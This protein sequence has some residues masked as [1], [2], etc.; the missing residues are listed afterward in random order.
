[1]NPFFSIEFPIVQTLL[2]RQIGCMITLDEFP[3]YLKCDCPWDYL[4]YFFSFSLVSFQDAV[5][6]RTWAYPVA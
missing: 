4:I 6:A 1:M 3:W 5:V 2:Y